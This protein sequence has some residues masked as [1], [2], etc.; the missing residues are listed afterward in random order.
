V[1]LVIIDVLHECPPQCDIQH[2]VAATDRKQWL[3][4]VY[5]GLHH[6]DLEVVIQVVD[7]VHGGVRLFAVARRVDVASSGDEHSVDT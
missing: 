1:L 4:C 2:L 6:L 3:V 7:V 5:T